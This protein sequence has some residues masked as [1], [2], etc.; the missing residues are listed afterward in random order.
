L[1][2]RGWGGW[3]A[4]VCWSASWR[5]SFGSEVIVPRC[6]ACERVG[7]CNE[8]GRGA[9]RHMFFLRKGIRFALIH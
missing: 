4:A 8:G 5:R 9:A 1:A 6:V 2:L 7:R 3:A